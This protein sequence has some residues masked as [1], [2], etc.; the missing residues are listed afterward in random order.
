MILPV[1]LL[2]VAAAVLITSGWLIRRGFA[3]GRHP[4]GELVA[5]QVAAWSFVACFISALILLAVPWVGSATSLPQLLERC[6]QRSGSSDSVWLPLAGR[7]AIGVVLIV[8]LIQL[9]SAAAA[10]ARRHHTQRVRQRQVLDLVASRD[11][12]RGYWTVRSDVAMAYCVPGRC[13]RVV[14]TSEA[15][16]RLSADETDAVCAHEQ[17]HLH[18]R[19]HWLITSV[20]LLVTAF[21]RVA[22][23]ATA[24]RRTVSLVEVHADEI[25]ARTVGPVAVMSAL[26]RLMD[27]PVQPW[28]ALNAAGL[29]TAERVAFLV[30][31]ADHGDDVRST[32]GR[33]Q[34]SWL[35]NTALLGIV[36]TAPML[37]SA[38]VHAAFC[39]V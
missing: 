19:H 7:I 33:P 17:A 12:Q 23:F 31:H 38:A 37:L 4:G 18:W 34:R 39:W 28:P 22:L 5:W 26:L 3:S 10:L 14:F 20:H 36:A 11:L 32:R 1:A 25:A 29:A 9:A 30:D 6:L 15:L 24:E 35:L 27:S 8:V 13:A 16:R 2:V 21:P